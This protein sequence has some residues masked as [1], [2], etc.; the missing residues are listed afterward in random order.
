ML[1]KSM[2]EKER[3][4]YVEIFSNGKKI[5][6][7]NNL[8]VY[9]GREKIA[10]MVFDSTGH[11]AVTHFGVGK[12][13]TSGGS[14][15]SP[16]NEDVDLADPIIIHSSYPD[17]GKKKAFSPSDISTNP[18]SANNNRN[19][20]KSVSLRLEQNEANDPDGIINEAGLYVSNGSQFYLYARIT[21]P[22]TPKDSTRSITF[23]WYLFF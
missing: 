10:D 6:E 8:V 18:D 2:N 20:I 13:G 9:E 23:I 19:L 22:D 3:K 7:I 12:G 4:N 1:K 11:M 15:V 21:F 14:V 5:H 16:T 17:G